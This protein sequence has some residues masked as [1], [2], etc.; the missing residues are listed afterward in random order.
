MSSKEIDK[1]IAQAIGLRDRIND[2]HVKLGKCLFKLHSHGL[3]TIAIADKVGIGY[4]KVNHLITIAKAVHDKH[5]P[6]SAVKSLGYAKSALLVPRV[7]KGKLPVSFLVEAAAMSVTDINKVIHG[8]HEKTA[9]V[10]VLT[11]EEKTVLDA[12]LAK[13][14]AL[15]H[16]LGKRS[17][18]LALMSILVKAG[19]AQ[20]SSKKTA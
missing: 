7:V 19:L 14:G 11:S 13:H 2:L 12:A 10:F 9:C 5:V 3:T 17:K 16:G 4:R 15:N 1:I 8:F 6:E 18:E 20:V